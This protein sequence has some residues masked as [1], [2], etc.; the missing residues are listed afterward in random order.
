MC[1]GW[2]IECDA[3]NLAQYRHAFSFLFTNPTSLLPHLGRHSIPS[4][5]LSL[6]LFF[7]PQYFI[8]SNFSPSLNFSLYFSNYRSVTFLFSFYHPTFYFLHFSRFFLRR[9]ICKFFI[10]FVRF[11][12]VLVG[13]FF[14]RELQIVR[15]L[16]IFIR[17]N[18]KSF[19][20]CNSI[21]NPS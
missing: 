4:F 1:V 14:C 13:G 7:L 20:N 19:V 10:R 11:F 15:E 3:D 17:K 5:N 9:K 2:Y 6:L 8:F 21:A 16:Q 18:G 12:K